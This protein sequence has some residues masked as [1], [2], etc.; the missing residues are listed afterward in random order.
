MLEREVFLVEG[1][2][3]DR[4]RMYG[5]KEKGINSDGNDFFKQ[6]CD[7]RKEYTGEWNTIDEIEFSHTEK[8][9]R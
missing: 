7:E 8:I 4:V 6:V 2:E 1:K 9:F 5:E 3:Y